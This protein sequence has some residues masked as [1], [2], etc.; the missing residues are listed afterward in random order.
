[1]EILDLIANVIQI[2]T[3]IPFVAGASYFFTKG[4][5][6]KRRLKALSD[7]PNNRPIALA[8][9]LGAE[10]V[11][12]V[13]QQL[14]DEGK[15]MEVVSLSIAGWVKPSEY[16]DLLK[17]LKQLK[18]EFSSIGVNEVHLYYQGPIT[19]AIAIGALFDNWVPIKVYSFRDGRYHL[20]ITLTTETFVSP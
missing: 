13:R 14:K 17:R 15:T 4:L 19:F 10:N 9:G 5:Q 7:I 11:G 18:N 3:F 2:V 8:V 16:L 12:A 6:L 20:D 1:M